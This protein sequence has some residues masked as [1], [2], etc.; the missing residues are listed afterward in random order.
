N[1]ILRGGKTTLWEG[2]LRVPFIARWPGRIK[3]GTTDHMTYF[4]DLLPTIAELAGASEHVPENI[5]GLSLVPVLLGAEAAGRAPE[6]HAYLYWEDA[7]VDWTSVRYLP[8]TTLRQAVRSGPWKAIRPEPGAPVQL[9]DVERDPGET[10]DVA[11]DHP[12]V[13][14]QIEAWMREAHVEP[15]PQDEPPRLEGRMYR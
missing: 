1:G 13:V 10:T 6:S 5:D 7:D 11:A 8:E 4:P 12:D 9:Y 2:G 15:P 14:A 3:P